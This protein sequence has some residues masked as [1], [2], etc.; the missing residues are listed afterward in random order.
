MKK[1]V[2]I[3]IQDYKFHYRAVILEVDMNKMIETDQFSKHRN[4]LYIGSKPSQWG[5]RGNWMERRKS[6]QQIVLE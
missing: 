3:I 1:K 2:G 4:K 6:F 5:C